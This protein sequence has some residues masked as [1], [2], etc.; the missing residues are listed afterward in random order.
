MSK[1]DNT[2]WV[3]FWGLWI[4]I[5]TY[6]LITTGCSCPVVSI[7][8]PPTYCEEDPNDRFFGTRRHYGL[9]HSHLR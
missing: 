4:L 7:D 3:F 1:S 6:L 5:L 2:G 9:R 8:P